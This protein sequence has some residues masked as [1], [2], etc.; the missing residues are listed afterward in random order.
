MAVLLE[1][2]DLEAQY[3][4][5]KVLHGLSFAV[6]AG[7]LVATYVR[8][9]RTGEEYGH[10]AGPHPVQAEALHGTRADLPVPSPDVTRQDLPVRRPEVTRQDLPVRSADLTRQDLPVRKRDTAPPED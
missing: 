7:L 1:A 3:G 10:Q 5:T 2:Q 6:F 4:W 8:G 9:R